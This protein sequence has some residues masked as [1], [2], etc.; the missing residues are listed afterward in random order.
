MATT[1]EDRAI[2]FIES[3][4]SRLASW[5]RFAVDVGAVALLLL[6][7]ALFFWRL[8][9]PN[10]ADRVAFPVGDF[11]DQYYPLRRFVAASLADGHLPFWN[12]YIF[13]GQP[14]LADPQAAV[15]YPPALLNA[16][17]WGANFPLI[18]LELEAVAHIALAAVGAYLFVRYALALDPL[19]SLAGAAVFGFGGYLTG[20]PLEQITILETSAW[21]PWLLLAIHHAV[22]ARLV[23]ERVRW[24]AVGALLLGMALLAGHPQSALYL[25]YV[26]VAYAIAHTSAQAIE[27]AAGGPAA[28]R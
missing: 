12:P 13:G 19:S 1:H 10:P 20:F 6:L 22:Q 9:A 21:L 26:S 5:R 2:P 4:T 24:S 16:L 25:L 28:K 3:S 27:I 14:G 17:F 11:T 23:H 18:A 8:W 15:L 7:V